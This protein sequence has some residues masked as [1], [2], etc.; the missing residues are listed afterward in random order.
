MRVALESAIRALVAVGGPPRGLPLGGFLLQGIEQRG[1]RNS[2]A[3][4]QWRQHVDLEPDAA[5]LVMAD[6]L[7]RK[8]QRIGELLLRHVPAAPQFGNALAQ[9]P[10]KNFFLRR[11]HVRFSRVYES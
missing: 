8:T 7:L 9:R 11:H 3:F 1:N 4:R 2:Q 10:V 5:D 6:G